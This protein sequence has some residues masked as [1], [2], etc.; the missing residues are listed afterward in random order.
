MKI[1]FLSL[2][3]I[4][5][6]AISPLLPARCRYFPTCSAYAEE[7]IKSHGAVKGGWLAVKRV[8]RCHPWGGQGYDPVPNKSEHTCHQE[9]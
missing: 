8:C 6:Y 5:R 4:Y 2:I 7:A 9:P 3:T 1:I